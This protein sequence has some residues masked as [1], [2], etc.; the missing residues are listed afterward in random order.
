MIVG[1]PDG[2]RAFAKLLT[3]SS[4]GLRGAAKRAKKTVKAMDAAGD[5]ADACE[6]VVKAQAG[7]F[8]KAAARLDTLVTLLQHSATQVEREIE[9]ERRRIEAERQRLEALERQRRLAAAK[10]NQARP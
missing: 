8:D 10:A 1:D 6:T 4:G 9:A 2:M 3:K 7:Q 5:W